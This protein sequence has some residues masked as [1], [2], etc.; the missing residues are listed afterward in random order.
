MKLVINIQKRHLFFGVF[1]FVALAGLVFVI[2]Q[3]PNPGHS[4]IG[5]WGEGAS[6]FI[7][8][9]INTWFEFVNGGVNTND[10][11]ITTLENTPLP[12][13]SCDTQEVYQSGAG[14]TYPLVIS[15]NPGLGFYEV[16][17]LELQEVGNACLTRFLVCCQVVP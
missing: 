5:I 10:G 4:S 7:D 11:R 1:V 12:G 9:P 2:A 3:V 15:C 8:S 14:C 13:L 6:G 16:L 17:N